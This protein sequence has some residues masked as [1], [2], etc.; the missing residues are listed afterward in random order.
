MQHGPED[1]FFQ[2]CEVFQLNKRGHN[3][4]TGLPFLRVIVVF[5]RGL[6]NRAA[7]GAHRLDMTL[8]VGF[9]LAINHRPDI[10]RQTAWIPHPTLR[11][12]AA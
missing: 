10:G 7:F 3:K 9:G 12:R 8:D 1:L 11:H 4:R 5:T 6:E 2:F